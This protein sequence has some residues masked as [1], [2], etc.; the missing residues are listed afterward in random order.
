MADKKTPAKT[1]KK[2]AGPKKGRIKKYFR[3]IRS[4]FRKI[5]WPSKKQVWNNTLVVIVTVLIFGIV[6]WTLDFLLV[7]GRDLLMG[8][9]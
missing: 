9:F 1:A 6:V 2:A 4:E 3:D 5:S 8:L 7:S